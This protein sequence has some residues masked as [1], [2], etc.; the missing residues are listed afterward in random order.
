MPSQCS[1]MTSTSGARGFLDLPAEIRFMVYRLLLCP[2]TEPIL[3]T[4]A[5]ARRGNPST[6]L[7]STCKA[8]C[9]EGSPVLYGENQFAL[10]WAY[11]G[12][13]SLVLDFFESVGS[14]NRCLIRHLSA[15]HLSI[16]TLSKIRVRRSLRQMLENLD[17]LTLECYYDSM[18]L[19]PDFTTLTIF[20]DLRLFLRTQRGPY[21]KLL[22]VLKTVTLHEDYHPPWRLRLIS[23]AVKPGPQVCR[24]DVSPGRLY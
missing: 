11:S 6:E 24:A 14:K 18:Y 1:T 23:D 5:H 2:S 17:S 21:R 13:E 3:A 19:G 12:A 7:L 4:L 16:R 15:R 8:C 20:R 9:D 10:D 22:R